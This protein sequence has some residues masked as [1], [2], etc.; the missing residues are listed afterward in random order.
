MAK[1]P[2]KWV[3]QRL[4]QY[5]SYFTDKETESRILMT[6]FMSGSAYT[7]TL[8]FCLSPLSELTASSVGREANPVL[9]TGT[10]LVITG[11]WGS[12]PAKV[13]S[14][15]ARRSPTCPHCVFIDCSLLTFR[16]LHLTTWLPISTPSAFPHANDNL[17]QIH[18]NN[19]LWRYSKTSSANNQG[20][21][22]AWRSPS[23][24][25]R[26]D[27]ITSIPCCPGDSSWG[28]GNF[29]SGSQWKM[30]QV[31]TVQLWERSNVLESIA[32]LFFLA[33]L[34]K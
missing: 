16:N 6:Q 26:G 29:T 10:N 12:F 18:F 34:C 7:K 4:L 28:T 13:I 30:L 33:L 24:L 23:T 32:V 1:R 2:V 25:D 9:K 22:W 17:F 11:V 14:H 31:T 19:F 3:G 20:E 27:Q 5:D 15:C 8:S 21:G